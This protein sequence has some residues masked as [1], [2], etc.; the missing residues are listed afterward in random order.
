MALFEKGVLVFSLTKQS[1][2]MLA[3]N[4]TVNILKHVLF[5]KEKYNV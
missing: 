3:V 4:E 2:N 1:M 5:I